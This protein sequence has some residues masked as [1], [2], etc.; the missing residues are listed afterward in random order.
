MFIHFLA[1]FRWLRLYLTQFLAIAASLCITTQLFVI[2]NRRL[3]H[4]LLFLC[5]LTYYISTTNSEWPREATIIIIYFRHPSSQNG[6]ICA[7]TKLISSATLDNKYS[8]G[9]TS[10]CL[11]YC[12]CVLQPSYIEYCDM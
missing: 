5:C 10:H 11:N 3:P 4:L 8:I 12:V 2:I 6:K 7:S 9:F 1:S